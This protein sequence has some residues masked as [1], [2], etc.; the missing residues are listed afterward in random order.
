MP[1]TYLCTATTWPLLTGPNLL[2]DLQSVVARLGDSI[3]IPPFTRMIFLLSLILGHSSGFLITSSRP[4]QIT[5]VPGDKVT[6]SCAVDDDYEWCKF[7]HPDG[8]FCDFEWKK[9]KGNITMQ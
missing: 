8:R 3:Q 6:L 9:R 1:H 5:V 2:R 7:Y 4:G